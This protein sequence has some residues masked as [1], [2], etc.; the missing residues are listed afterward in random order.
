[1]KTTTMAVASCGALALAIAL[2]TWPGAR[3]QDG[4]GRAGPEAQRRQLRVNQEVDPRASAM[5]RQMSDYL[6]SIRTVAV[7]AD[8][9]TEVVSN[10]G[11]KLQ[12]L[13]SSTVYVER[14]N[15]MR[16]TRHGPLAD[17]TFVYD[18]NEVTLYDARRNLYAS[19]AAPHDIDQ[20]ID[21]ARGELGI[22]AP[23]ADLLYHDVYG[24][25]MEGVRSG[26]YV[27]DA[28]VDGH[29]CHQLAFRNDDVDWQIWID[30]GDRPLPR[31]YV[32]TTKDYPSE[33]QFTVALLDWDTSPSL[34]P[35]FFRAR[36]PEGAQRIQ[37]LGETSARAKGGDR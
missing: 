28:D 18:G 3:A 29:L 35:G 12:V 30:A 22:D 14:P 7:S 15:R 34:P 24:A 33:P 23:A 11:H 6:A 37:F 13:A 27:G 17:L 32:I 25:L 26:T 8:N 20:M 19:T 4:A 2:T 9:V 31:R 36:V 16:A 21:F 10:D 5:M 1:M